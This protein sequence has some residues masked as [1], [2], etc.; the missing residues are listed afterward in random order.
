M[1]YLPCR[2]HTYVYIYMQGTTYHFINDITIIIIYYIIFMYDL[3]HYI[4]SIYAYTY[5]L[6]NNMLMR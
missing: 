2:Y 5:V 4:I 3:A 1:P 6:L